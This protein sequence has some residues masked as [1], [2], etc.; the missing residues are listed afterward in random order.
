LEPISADSNTSSPLNLG[1]GRARLEVHILQEVSKLGFLGAQVANVIGGRLGE[2]GHLVH[3]FEPVARESVDLLWIVRVD[4]HPP[5][6]QVVQDL[7]PDP[8]FT[9][10]GLESKGLVGLDRV[11]PAVL[12]L[13]GPELVGEADP[14][15]R[16]PEIQEHRPLFAGELLQRLVQLRFAITALQAEDV[17]RQAFRMHAD[18][19]N[20]LDAVPRTIETRARHPDRERHVLL[21]VYLT[22]CV[23][24]RLEPM[25][26]VHLAVEA[27]RILR[28][29]MGEH[30][31]ILSIL[32][33]G[34]ER[35]NL[36]RLVRDHG[37]A[38]RVRFADTFSYPDP[39]LAQIGRHDLRLL[40]NLND[41]Q[42]RVIF[43]AI[44][45]GLAPICPDSRPYRELGIDA[46][47]SIVVGTP[48]PWRRRFARSMSGRWRF[49]LIQ[50]LIRRHAPWSFWREVRCLT[51]LSPCRSG[52]P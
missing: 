34:R 30:A 50:S 6:A 49:S 5:D 21:A 24:T 25:K 16:L 19:D 2:Q 26:G 9:Q 43:D 13:I 28:P 38:D 47:C 42:P 18:G 23:A 52:N 17:S 48:T 4:P 32:G 51:R 31:P 27:L 39:F 22:M 36:D 15:P 8:V 35:E 29:R 44:S 1:T 14:T 12:E 11:Q 7:G 33:E 40:T 46:V 20:L 37:L 41:E 45:Q 3:Q 10:V